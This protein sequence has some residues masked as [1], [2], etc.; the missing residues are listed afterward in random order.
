MI[1]ANVNLN[2]YFCAILQVLQI[3]PTRIC[4]HWGIWILRLRPP[5]INGSRFSKVRAE[6][7]S[8]EQHA[9]KNVNN[10]LNT[11]LLRDIWW[12]KL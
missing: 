8:M 2:R 5:E 7:Y 3:R 11:L 12:S 6:K 1:M 4:F 9:F 10:C